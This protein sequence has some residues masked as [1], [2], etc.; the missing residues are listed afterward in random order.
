[1]AHPAN[2][3]I[4]SRAE[5]AAFIID[6]DI[7]MTILACGRRID[8]SSEPVSHKLSTVTYPQHRHSQFKHAVIY[9]R[10]AFT[11]GTLRTA[12]KYDPLR[13][14]GL[15]IIK[16]HLVISADF[17]VH[18]AFAHAP[19]DE[20]VVLTSEIQYQYSVLCHFFLL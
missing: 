2:I 9:T 4:V 15:D 1:M 10:R 16:V 18:P 11:V 19:C 14:I 13:I 7:R 3:H 8:L 6:Y 12:R 17:T 5:D 20:L